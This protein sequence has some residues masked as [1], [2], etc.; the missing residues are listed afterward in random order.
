MVLVRNYSAIIY[1]SILLVIVLLAFNFIFAL[2]K[3]TPEG[4]VKTSMKIK[5]ITG[6]VINPINKTQIT[7]STNTNNKQEIYSEKAYVVFYLFLIGVLIF[8][9]ILSITLIF[10]KLKDYT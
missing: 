3:T 9:A 6:F 2:Q 8:I 10:P 5:Q 1:L 7:N 4:L